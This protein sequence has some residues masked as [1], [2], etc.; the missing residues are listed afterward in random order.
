M[1]L[2]CVDNL[3][4]QEGIERVLQV[5]T[6]VWTPRQWVPPRQRRSSRARGCG[7][8]TALPRAGAIL[9][10]P[11]CLSRVLLFLFLRG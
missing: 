6:W 9:L 3:T 2:S 5:R 4:V 10:T 1:R 8:W 11:T 7:T